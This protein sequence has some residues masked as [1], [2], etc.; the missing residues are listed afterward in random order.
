MRK[1]NSKFKQ[2]IQKAEGKENGST[3]LETSRSGCE[4]DPRY[5]ILYQFMRREISKQNYI[6]GVHRLPYTERSAIAACRSRLGVSLSDVDSMGMYIGD[7]RAPE[8][9]IEQV[10]SDQASERQ[11]EV[12]GANA[13]SAA[14]TAR[15]L[16]RILYGPGSGGHWADAID[17][18]TTPS[19][20]TPTSRTR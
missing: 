7:Q 6:S 1:R 17:W 13:S 12:S 8:P 19:A 20:A 5:G 9:T 18:G 14:E 16:Y 15:S 11:A 2:F 3:I 10:S 4:F